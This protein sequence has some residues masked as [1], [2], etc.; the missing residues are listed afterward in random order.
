MAPRSADA[1][2][3]VARRIYAF[4][5]ARVSLAILLIGLVVEIAAVVSCALTPEQQVRGIPKPVWLLVILLFPV[6]GAVL[7]FVFGRD[8]TAPRMRTVAPDDDPEFLRRLGP[9]RRAPLPARS[10][11][12]TLRRLEQDLGA[13]DPDPDDEDDPGRR[14]G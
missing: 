3:G 14:R 2:G 4:R 5:M 12:E 8:R 7:W 11:E 6:L 13:T 1:A 9:S 10:D